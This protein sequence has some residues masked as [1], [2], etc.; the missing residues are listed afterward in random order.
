MSTAADRIC[1]SVLFESASR[2][3]NVLL[4][5]MRFYES[6]QGN[7]ENPTFSSSSFLYSVSMHSSSLLIFFLFSLQIS[8]LPHPCLAEY[9]LVSRSPRPSNRTPKVHL[10]FLPSFISSFLFRFPIFFV[11][12]W[13]NAVFLKCSRGRFARLMKISLFS[14]TPLKTNRDK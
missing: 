9:F 10:L 14:A 7:H 4:L 2:D 11:I 5:R 3:C 1:S 6:P 12:L 13:Q 8:R